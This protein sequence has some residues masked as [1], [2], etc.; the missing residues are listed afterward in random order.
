MAGG[1]WCHACP[2][3]MPLPPSPLRSARRCFDRSGR[4]RCPRQGA[5]ASRPACTLHE[6][7]LTPTRRPPAAHCC[8]PAHHPPRPTARC[9][10]DA[11][12]PP[13]AWALPPL[14][15]PL[16]GVADALERRYLKKMF[17]G[18]SRD[19]EGKDLLEEVGCWAG[20]GC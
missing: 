16:T 6:A 1:S 4:P 10:A 7:H 12:P 14:P 20:C 3:S 2:A 5:P 19:A 11:A 17:F 15:R 9:P 18:I 13:P 8:P